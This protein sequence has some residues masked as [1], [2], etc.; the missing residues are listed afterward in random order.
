MV[1]Q[2]STGY[3]AETNPTFTFSNEASGTGSNFDQ[4]G[5]TA[6]ATFTSY[7]GTVQPGMSVSGTNIPAGTVVNYVVVE[8][9][10]AA[11]VVHFTLPTS[12]SLSTPSGT[13]TFEEFYNSST[14]AYQAA[15]AAQVNGT[16]SSTTA[17]VV[18]NNVG[19]IAVGDV[20]TG[21]GISGS[22]T[23]VSLTNQNN[24]VLSSAQSLTND[25]A[26][27]FTPTITL[28]D[29]GRLSITRSYNSVT[30]TKYYRY[31]IRAVSPADLSSSFSGSATLDSSNDFAL[32]EVIQYAKATININA[33]SDIVD[34]AGT[35][36]NIRNL[37]DTVSVSSATAD[38]KTITLAS[39]DSNA[40]IQPGM[41]VT[42][43]NILAKTRVESISGTT[44]VID[45]TPT[46]APS[47]ELKFLD[48][49]QFDAYGEPEPV[50]PF[51]L[52]AFTVIASVGGTTTLTQQRN[53]IAEDDFEYS[54]ITL[55]SAN[56]TSGNVG[57]SSGAVPDS[58]AVGSVITSDRIT[59]NHSDKVITVGAIPS[60]SAITLAVDGVNLTG[61]ASTYVTGGDELVFSA[62]YGWDFSVTNLSEAITG[63]NKYT[64]TGQI[65]VARYGNQN[66]S[67]GLNL[68]NIIAR[69]TSGSGGATT[70]TIPIS[71]ISS[72]DYYI[73]NIIMYPKQVAVG[74]ATSENIGFSG[75]VIG[76]W[77]GNTI[78]GIK[79]YLGPGTTGFKNSSSGTLVTGSGTSA[80]VLVSLTST[81][82]T[83]NQSPT[84]TQATFSFTLRLS[85][86]AAAG[87]SLIVEPRIFLPDQY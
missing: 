67:V 21:T 49:A 65:S 35:A 48:N 3:D 10:T 6:T 68:N 9:T 79:L 13:I 14:Q 23:V 60:S 36:I 38:S 64:L 45:Q 61:G 66:L 42:G 71:T 58:L 85:A 15:A 84:V 80:D 31:F 72:T 11:I 24:L 34:S 62:P 32:C 63:N 50:E 51:G 44:L 2:G 52:I 54:E 69:A 75:T 83:A 77:D 26:L 73:S 18:N 12:A 29:S 74:T 76:N 47:G 82:T 27:A 40:L 17:L 56:V 30:A 39:S 33:T 53:I 87:Q 4:D 59:T 55:V 57:F 5:A 70:T 1:I 28:T 22:V 41:L 25:V 43:T 19:T 46:S 78:S 16:T 20:V 7:I 86:T 8:C 81:L 37:P